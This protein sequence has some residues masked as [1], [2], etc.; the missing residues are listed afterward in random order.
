MQTLVFTAHPS[1]PAPP[2]MPT[3]LLLPDPSPRVTFPFQIT[4]LH[5]GSFCRHVSHL[6]VND[7]NDDVYPAT[8]GESL[9][10]SCSLLIISPHI[11]I[12]F[13][14]SQVLAHRLSFLLDFKAQSER[15][16]L[17]ETDAEFESYKGV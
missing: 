9:E 13:G 14:F 2:T 10:L 8:P 11:Q 16:F 15:R 3:T 4:S 5:L 7:K 12:Q 6:T 1:P 17:N